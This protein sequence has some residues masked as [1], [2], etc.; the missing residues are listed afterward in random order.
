[1]LKVN[2]QTGKVELELNKWLFGFLVLVIIAL[3]AAVVGLSIHA[4]KKSGMEGSVVNYQAALRFGSERGDAV[5]VSN[6]TGGYAAQAPNYTDNIDELVDDLHYDSGLG[7]ANEAHFF[8]ADPAWAAFEAMV[9]PR[10]GTQLK[11]RYQNAS[12]AEQISVLVAAGTK[13]GVTLPSAAPALP[14]PV[15]TKSGLSVGQ[16]AS[17]YSNRAGLRSNIADADIP[18]N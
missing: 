4:A 11:A 1:M 6:F 16:R 12:T 7:A 2:E 10:L 13:L 17:G 15:S 8:A 18:F 9:Y 3:V 14:A 5:G